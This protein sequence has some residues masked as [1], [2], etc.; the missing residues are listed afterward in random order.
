LKQARQ[1]R[2]SRKWEVRSGK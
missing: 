1:G 2:A